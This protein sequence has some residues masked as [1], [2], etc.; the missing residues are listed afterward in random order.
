MSTLAGGDLI[1]RLSCY[2]NNYYCIIEKVQFFPGLIRVYIDVRGDNS[3][4]M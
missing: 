1:Q 4:G 3:L 2:N